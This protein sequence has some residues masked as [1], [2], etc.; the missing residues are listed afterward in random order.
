[1]TRKDF[2]ALAECIRSAGLLASQ[3]GNPDSFR[4]ACKMIAEFQAS[5]MGQR[6]TR[7][8]REQFIKAAGVQL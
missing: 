3:S 8:D 2:E 7:F 1:M 6:N 4:R 5:H